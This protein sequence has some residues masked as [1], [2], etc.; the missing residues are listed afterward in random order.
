MILFLQPTVPSKKSR[1]P[2]AFFSTWLTHQAPFW[3]NA[4]G[5]RCATRI[6]HTHSRSS[7]VPGAASSGEGRRLERFPRRHNAPRGG[8]PPEA[9]IPGEWFVCFGLCADLQIPRYGVA[10]LC[11]IVWMGCDKCKMITLNF[12]CHKENVV[13]LNSSHRFPQL[14]LS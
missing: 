5:P 11:G 2:F 14:G 8:R 9:R 4:S 13:F 7:L 1:S 12:N 6:T 3:N 10:L